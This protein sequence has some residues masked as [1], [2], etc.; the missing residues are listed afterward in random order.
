MGEEADPRAVEVPAPPTALPDQQELFPEI[1]KQQLELEAQ[2]L[3]NVTRQM[4]IADK[5]IQVAEAADHQQ[6]TY[7]MTVEQNRSQEAERTHRILKNIVNVGGGA[8]VLLVV[9][10]FF[11]VFFGTPEQSAQA[12]TILETLGTAVGGGA[13]YLIFQVLAPFFSNRSPTPP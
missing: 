4:E 5:A 12:M 8:G 10:L 1:L 11:A 6:F 3:A 9:W 13:F 2:R 7:H